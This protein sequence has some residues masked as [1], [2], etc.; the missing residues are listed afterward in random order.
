MHARHEVHYAGLWNPRNPEGPARAH[1]YSSRYYAIRHSPPEKT[2][3]A[4]ALQLARGL[5][6]SMPVPVFR[7][8]SDE[9]RAQV[10]RLR[11]EGS[12][13]HVVCDFLSSAPH[14]S[15][16]SGVVLRGAEKI[17]HNMIE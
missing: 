15:D 7:Y 9:M 4:F 8:C 3:P 5:F 17:A 12:F 6:T 13:D 2:S 10:D 11:R 14:F 1:E 16:L